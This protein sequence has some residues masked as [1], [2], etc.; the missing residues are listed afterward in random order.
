MTAQVTRM[1]DLVHVHITA[2][3]PVRARTLPFADRLEIRFGNAYP[4]A[5]IV[6]RAALDRL[7]EA[8]QAGRVELEA[9]DVHKQKGEQS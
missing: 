2:D 8:I 7:G 3:L 4:V 1:R 5:L 6:D 9:A